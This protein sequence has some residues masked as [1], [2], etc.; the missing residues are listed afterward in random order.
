MPEVT[1]WVV[2]NSLRVLDVL[3]LRDHPVNAITKVR[4]TSGKIG[5]S[6]ALESRVVSIGARLET[7]EPD[8]SIPLRLHESH[9]LQGRALLVVPVLFDEWL[10]SFHDL[11]QLVQRRTRIGVE[12]VGRGNRPM[13]A[14]MIIPMLFCPSLVPCAKLT[15]VQV[16]TSIPRIHQEGALSPAGW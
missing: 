3:E 1:M 10:R 9:G 11:R 7:C 5:L 6:A 12:S 8:Y 14:S 15:A 16:K 4:T 2:L 13:M